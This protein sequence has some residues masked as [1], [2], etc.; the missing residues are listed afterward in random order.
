MPPQVTVAIPCYNAE[1]WIG[2]AI[3]SA[4]EQQDVTVEVIVVDDGSTD[5][6][7]EEIRAITDRRV[8]FLE[9]SHC[10]ANPARNLAL[11]EAAGEW[12]QFLDADDYLLPQKLARQLRDG[13]D[14][15]VIYSPVIFDQDGAQ[16]PSAMDSGRRL[17]ALWLAWELPQTGGCLWRKERLQK[18]GGWN[19]ATPCCQEYELYARA[20]RA[21]LRFRFSPEPGAVYRV[22]S[23]GSLCRKDPLQVVEVR[24]ALFRD[25]VAWLRDRGD[26]REDERQLA[27]RAFFEMAR[28]TAR[29]DLARATRYHRE[30]HRAGLIHATGP[31]APASYRAAYKLLGFSWAESFARTLRGGKSETRNPK[32]E[33]MS[34][35]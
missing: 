20:I 22:W 16:T 12:V 33:T 17:E 8:R 35:K 6:S 25:F 19:E 23:E 5:R 18:L 28:T 2:A 34:E 15:D 3:R 10:G 31:A 21:G 11:R 7:R 29:Y 13:A 4:L 30:H 27:G 32:S 26:L 14:T 24:T 1:R 9:G